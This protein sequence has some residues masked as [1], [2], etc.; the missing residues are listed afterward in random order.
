MRFSTSLVFVLMVVTSSIAFHGIR[1]IPPNPAPQAGKAI[2][3]YLAVPAK[4]ERI[5]ERSCYD[6][7]SNRTRW[8]WYTRLP[9]ISNIVQDDVKRARSHLNFSD[10]SAKLAEGSDEAQAALNGIC[11]EL[12]TDSMPMPRYRLLH[13]HTALSPDEVQE[14]CHWTA[15]AKLR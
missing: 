10:W 5:F 8:P 6:C 3:D 11:E 7:H 14:V 1:R 13:R 9:G 12:R 15:D 2:T 4:V